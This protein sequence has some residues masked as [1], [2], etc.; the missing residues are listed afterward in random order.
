MFAFGEL[1][2][3]FSYHSNQ[4]QHIIKKIAFTFTTLDYLNGRNYDSTDDNR[5]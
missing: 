1:V 2:N 4:L 5:D 3:D